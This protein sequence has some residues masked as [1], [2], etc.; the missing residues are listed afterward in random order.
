MEI[1]FKGVGHKIY[2]LWSLLLKILTFIIK[3]KRSFINQEI[4]NTFRIF[5]AD[6]RLSRPFFV[7]KRGNGYFG[8]YMG[9][10]STRNYKF[11]TLVV[12]AYGR[13]NTNIYTSYIVRY[14]NLTLSGLSPVGFN[15]NRTNW[16]FAPYY[17]LKG[18][19]G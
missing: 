8:H 5:C 1:F 16:L 18:H 15:K 6:G 17:L 14:N 19:F 4:I 7:E 9:G 12:T 3:L 2:N 10:L 13:I 11:Q